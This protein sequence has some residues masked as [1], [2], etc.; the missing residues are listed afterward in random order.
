MTESNDETAHGAGSRES[1]HVR[2][3]TGGEPVAT[4]V[5]VAVSDVLGTA[6]DDLRPIAEVLDADA[7]NDLF[8][9]NRG[10]DV[11]VRFQYERC[12]VIVDDETI[13]VEPPQHSLSAE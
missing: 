12:S 7:L 3:A 8:A 4:Q 9:R 1:R 13:A 2:E 11:T 6:A 10:T 5:V